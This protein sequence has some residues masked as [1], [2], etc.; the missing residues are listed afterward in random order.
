MKYFLVLFVILFFAA[1]DAREEVYVKKP[2]PFFDE[3][4]M[5]EIISDLKLTEGA[6]QQMSAYGDDAKM[7]SQ[8]YYNKVLQKH[9]ISAEEFKANLVYYS[10]YPD[11]MHQIYSRVVNRLTEMHT[12]ISN[13]K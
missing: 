1:C 9:Q 12:E 8:Y 2:Q 3:E 10:A 5:V 13:R 4:K 7:V 6:I 11:I